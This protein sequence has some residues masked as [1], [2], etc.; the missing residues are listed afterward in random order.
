MSAS[1]FKSE[2]CSIILLY[3][4]TKELLYTCEPKQATFITLLVTA[5]VLAHIHTYIIWFSPN[6]VSLYYVYL[7]VRG[8]SLAAVMESL[9]REC[10]QTGFVTL[11]IIFRGGSGVNVVMMLSVT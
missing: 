5:A 11:N 4:H 2:Y 9:V 7:A 8:G 6:S 3:I 10:S 1:E